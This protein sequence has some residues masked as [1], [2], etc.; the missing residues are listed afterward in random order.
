MKTK[1]GTILAAMAV[2]ATAANGAEPVS[3]VGKV[4]GTYIQDKDTDQY[5]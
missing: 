1:C 4:P 5:F 2:L 3:S